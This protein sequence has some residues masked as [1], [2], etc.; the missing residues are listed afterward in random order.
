MI[1]V[2]FFG[3]GLPE[4][5]RQAVLTILGS[6]LRRSSPSGRVTVFLVGDLA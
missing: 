6:Q 4:L 3:S 1:C 5:K 2:A